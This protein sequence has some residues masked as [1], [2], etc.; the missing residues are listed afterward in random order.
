M[1]YIKSIKHVQ[2]SYPQVPKSTENMQL[3]RSGEIAKMP[4]PPTRFFQVNGPPITTLKANLCEF[5]F[6][7]NVLFHARNPTNWWQNYQ[8]IPTY[9]YN[10]SCLIIP[11]NLQISQWA[12]PTR[13]SLLALPMQNRQGPKSDISFLNLR[14]DD[15]S[16]WAETVGEKQQQHPTT[17][18]TTTTTTSTTSTTWWYRGYINTSPSKLPSWGSTCCWVNHIFPQYCMSMSIYTYIYICI[19]MST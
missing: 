11:R 16:T 14:W 19:R 9:S 8:P 15:M 2:W 18:T 12:C 7:G 17:T 4:N 6:K 1:C 5:K 3:C 13:T 10:I